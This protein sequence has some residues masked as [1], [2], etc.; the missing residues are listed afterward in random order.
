MALILAERLAAAEVAQA[1]Q[2]SIEYDPGPP[3]DAGAGVGLLT[4]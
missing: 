1:V 2:L 3:F 4:R